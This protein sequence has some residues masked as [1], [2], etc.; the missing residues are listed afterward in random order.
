MDTKFYNNAMKIA[1]QKAASSTNGE[2]KHD[3]ETY[4]LEFDRTNWY[5]KV[6]DD[7]GSFVVNLSVKGLSKAKSELRKWLSS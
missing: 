5:Y 2:L 3:G 7:K 1:E 6:T 4:K